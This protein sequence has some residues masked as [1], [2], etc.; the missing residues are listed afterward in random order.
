MKVL[1]KGILHAVELD[2]TKELIVVEE[3]DQLKST[4]YVK[5][6]VNMCSLTLPILLKRPTSN[7]QSKCGVELSMSQD[8]TILKN[9]LKTNGCRSEKN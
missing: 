2:H 6:L 4:N 9:C 7:S 3:R 8:L 5:M 1:R